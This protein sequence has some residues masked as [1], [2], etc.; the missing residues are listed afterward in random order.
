MQAELQALILTAISIALLHTISGPDHYLPFIVLSKTRGWGLSKTIGWTIACGLGHV[1]S[2]VV[3]ALGA[4]AIGW[5]FSKIVWIENV[6]G[7]LAGWLMLLFGFFYLIWGMIKFVQNKSHKHFDL[8]VEGS[9]YVFEHVHGRSVMPKERFKVTPW[10]MFL[11]FVL[12]P[13]E[14]LIPLLYFPAIQNSPFGLFILIIT[15]TSITILSMLGLVL[16][17]YFGIVFS[18]SVKLEKYIHIL[19]AFATIVCA[20]GIL[21][22]GW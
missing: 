8:D 15:Y 10:V 21:W 13:C 22:L 9:L 5:S 3:I 4:A 11:I 18:I 12:G 19:G 16:L 14:P 17:G 2:S 1:L 6:R 7:G 20:V